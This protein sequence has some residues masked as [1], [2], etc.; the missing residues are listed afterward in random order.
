MLKMTYKS[1]H[2]HG[3]ILDTVVL[4][5]ALRQK[6]RFRVRSA[7]GLDIGVF[8]PR[9]EVLRQGDCLFS[10]EGDVLRV[11]AKEESVTTAF[12]PDW[13]TF[14]RACYH[15]GNRHVPLE[16]GELWLRFQPDH[17][18]EQMVVLFGLECRHHRAP[19]N[20]ENGAYAAVHHHHREH[21]H[22]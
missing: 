5:F 9:G 21:D 16:M 8:L 19:F 14:A 3:A 20:P 10:E 1:D 2:H 18:L 15:L 4:P 7:T 22:P 12:A 6:G 11:E 17:V 13:M